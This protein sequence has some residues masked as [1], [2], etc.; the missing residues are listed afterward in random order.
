MDP[1]HARTAR[2][3]QGFFSV[4]LAPHGETA[5]DAFGSIPISE[6]KGCM[7]RAILALGEQDVDVSAMK[8]RI[9]ADVLGASSDHLI[10]D[11]GDP[12]LEVGVEVRFDVSCGALLRGRRRRPTWKRC[13]CPDLARLMTGMRRCGE[14]SLIARTCTA[15]HWRLLTVG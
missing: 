2:N 6:G 1:R 10:L 3:L 14:P 9:A 7:K 15:V 13:T 12:G 5:Q 11:A 4:P 8:P